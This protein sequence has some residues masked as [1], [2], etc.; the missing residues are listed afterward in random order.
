MLGMTKPTAG[1]PLRH[2]S[3]DSII[4]NAVRRHRCDSGIMIVEYYAHSHAMPGLSHRSPKKRHARRAELQTRM[5]VARDGNNMY[6]MVSMTVAPCPLP[7]S[8]ANDVL[9]SLFLRKHLRDLRFGHDLGR[10][11]VGWSSRSAIA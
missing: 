3:I 4:K 8:E 10:R 7:G 1:S 11:C 6:R 5:L 2:C 9:V